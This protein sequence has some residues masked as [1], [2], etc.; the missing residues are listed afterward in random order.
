[1]SRRVRDSSKPTA[2]N[3]DLTQ[4]TL[5]AAEFAEKN[6]TSRETGP[7]AAVRVKVRWYWWE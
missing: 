7:F 1:M 6:G 3:K 2:K 5:G 4:R